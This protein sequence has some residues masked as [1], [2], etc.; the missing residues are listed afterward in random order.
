[1]PIVASAAI[2]ARAARGD[3]AIAAI[4]CQGGNYDIV[5]AIL[6]TATEESAPVILMAY[7]A[8]TAYY[9]LDWLPRLAG[10]LSPD[11]PIPVAVHLDHA[12]DP[13][14]VKTAIGCGYTSVMIDCSTRPLEE[15][16]RVTEEVIAAARPRG[17]SV[18]AEIGELQRNDGE[19]KRAP[20]NLV[21]PQ[22]VRRFVARVPVDLLAVGIGNVHGFYKGEPNIRV[23]LLKRVKEIV[24][25]LPLV[26][27]GSTGIPAEV[28]T[29]CIA[30][31][32]AK[33]N[34]GTIVRV[35]FVDFVREA[36]EDESIHRGHIWRALQ[37]AKDRLK[38]NI[39]QIIRMTGSAGKA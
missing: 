13:D 19:E 22:D 37:H 15:N 9:G 20:R 18:E 27:H 14:V 26:L 2:V 21:D 8:N 10:V 12:G 7:H 28:V 16:M 38:D 35:R 1:M 4:N 11:Y 36:L 23:D 24:G 6:E 39:R 5:R 25:E 34:F 30:N 3:Y 17:V 31:G 29:E 33:I 32:V